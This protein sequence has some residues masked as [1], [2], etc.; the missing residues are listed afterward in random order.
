MSET[1]ATDG[2]TQNNNGQLAT[3]IDRSL[4][5]DK[6]DVVLSNM[7]VKVGMGFGVGVVTSVLLFRRRAFPV[8]LGIGFGVGR[9]YSEGDAIFRSTSGIRTVKV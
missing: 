2:A 9:G 5:N 4:L 7:L 3:K 6:W 8:W 1:T